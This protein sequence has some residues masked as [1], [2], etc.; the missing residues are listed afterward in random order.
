MA[1]GNPHVC[2]GDITRDKRKLAFQTGENDSTL[3]VYYVPAFP[4]VLEGRRPEHRRGPRLLPLQ[5]PGGRRVRRA[6]V[7]ARRRRDRLA[8]G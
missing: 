5:R 3:T 4:T 6:D 1:D 8:R 2:G 7:L